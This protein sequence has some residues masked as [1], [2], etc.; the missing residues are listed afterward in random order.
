M[1]ADGGDQNDRVFGMAERSSGCEIICC[2]AGWG[3]YADTVRLHRCEVFVV[4]ED[5]DG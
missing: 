2:G 4:A 3:G 5:F 1:C